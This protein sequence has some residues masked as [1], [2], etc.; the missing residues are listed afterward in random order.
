MPAQLVAVEGAWSLPAYPLQV[1]FSALQSGSVGTHTA[2]VHACAAAHAAT[3]TAAPSSND[4]VTTYS[5]FAEHHGSTA[6]HSG[7]SETEDGDC[8]TEYD[9][10][11]GSAGAAAEV[12]DDTPD[13]CIWA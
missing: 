2:P 3:Q 8:D 5:S 6:A 11:D 7:H 13:M 9:A 12:A 1:E 10:A 4:T